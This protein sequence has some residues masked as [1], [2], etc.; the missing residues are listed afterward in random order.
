MIKHIVIWSFKATEFASKEE[1]IQKFKSM[2]LALP[3]EIKEIKSMEIGLKT[4]ESPANNNDMVLT[5]THATWEDLSIY[6]NHPKH[7]DVVA[8]AK[9]IVESRSAVDYVI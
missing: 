1:N 7:L 2:L 4:S 5:T 3:S 9:Q 6:A 8:F